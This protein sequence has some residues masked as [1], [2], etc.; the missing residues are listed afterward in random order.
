MSEI[1]GDGS[2]HALPPFPTEGI[3]ICPFGD[4]TCPCPD[5][6]PCHYV[7]LPGSPGMKPPVAQPEGLSEE[8]R[9]AIEWWVAV[10][11]ASSSPSAYVVCRTDEVFQII[12]TLLTSPPP[13][14]EEENDPE[15]H[16]QLSEAAL[17]RLRSGQPRRRS[18]GPPPLAP[19]VATEA[20]LV[21][22]QR[23]RDLP[24]QPG[25]SFSKAV[26]KMRSLAGAGLTVAEHAGDLEPPSATETT[27]PP[28][29]GEPRQE[30]GQ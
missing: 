5:G 18:I 24:I 3:D 11:R 2:G 17:Q 30:G 23:I 10:G 12:D 21:A 6:D 29:P 25:Q 26:A 16:P 27:A 22:L 1:H 28:L 14:Q 9:G 20:M 15:E 19:D 4:P 7:D 13:R 8:D